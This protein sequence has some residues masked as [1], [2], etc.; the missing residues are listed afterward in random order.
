MAYVGRCILD[1]ELVASD[2]EPIADIQ[3]VGTLPGRAGGRQEA[4]EPAAGCQGRAGCV[5]R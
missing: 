3:E 5:F 1:C 2:W 4:D